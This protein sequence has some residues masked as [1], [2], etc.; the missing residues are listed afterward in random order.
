[1]PTRTSEMDVGAE[2]DGGGVEG[3]GIQ[4]ESGKKAEEKVFREGGWCDG[5]WEGKG[6][7]WW[8]WVTVFIHNLVAVFIAYTLTRINKAI[9]SWVTYQDFM[10]CPSATLGSRLLFVVLNVTLMW[11]WV[12]QILE[13]ASIN[14]ME[15]IARVKEQVRWWT[16]E[17]E[18]LEGVLGMVRDIEAEHQLLSETPARGH[19]QHHSSS[20]THDVAQTAD[21]DGWIGDKTLENIGSHMDAGRQDGEGQSESAS[22]GSEDPNPGAILARVVSGVSSSSRVGAPSGRGGGGGGGGGARSRRGSGVKR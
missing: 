20:R 16:R 6:V 11:N 9:I 2:R 3:K 10:R 17:T 15:R 8:V 13:E 5:D 12:R 21:S 7:W 19:H 4:W 18:R 22:S 1:M 14:K